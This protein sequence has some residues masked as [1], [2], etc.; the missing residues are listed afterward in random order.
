MKLWNVQ[1][2]NIQAALQVITIVCSRDNSTVLFA[3]KESQIHQC[4]SLRNQST[5]MHEWYQQNKHY[6]GDGL[7]EL[8]EHQ[9]S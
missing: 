7:H 4:E 9:L 8:P 5:G 1:Q 3:N 6:S 2:K